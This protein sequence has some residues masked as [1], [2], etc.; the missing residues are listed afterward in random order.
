M[1][2]KSKAEVRKKEILENFYEVIKV[3]GYE[4]ASI[5]K[6]AERMDVNPSLLIHY[7]KTKEEMV[8]D[9]VDFI[10][11]R[12]EQ[13]FMNMLDDVTDAQKRFDLITDIMY[14]ASWFQVS[15]RSVFYA[16]YYLATR[17]ERIREHFK[18]MYDRFREFLIEELDRWKAAK[19]IKDV[20]SVMMSQYMILMN[21][22]HTYYEGVFR[23]QE[24]F[25]KRSTFVRGLV[26][27]ALQ[28]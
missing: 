1:G 6:I 23:S 4:N 2:R 11:S 15:D 18:K 21:E 8:V 3:E 19:I 5:A 14:G 24:E 22:G 10:L 20:D 12:Y 28:G 26:L 17:H 9:L 16:C 25:E 7:F 27:N 13:T